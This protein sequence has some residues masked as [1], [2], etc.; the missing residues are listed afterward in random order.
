MM[1]G[2][3]HEANRVGC[4]SLALEGAPDHAH[5]LKESEGVGIVEVTVLAGLLLFNLQG[6]GVGYAYDQVL[7]AGQGLKSVLQVMIV[8]RLESAV[9]HSVVGTHPGCLP[10]IF[11]SSCNLADAVCTG[12]QVGHIW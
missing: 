4:D 2:E 10:F 6:I 11:R 12:S 5:P 1:N 3:G 7:A 8:K 9:D